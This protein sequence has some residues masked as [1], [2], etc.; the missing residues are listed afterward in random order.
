MS[1]NTAIERNDQRERQRA[2]NRLR[3]QCLAGWKQLGRLPERVT[4]S[5]PRRVEH[6]IRSCC[7]LWKRRGSQHL[8]VFLGPTALGSTGRQSRSSDK[9]AK[10]EVLDRWVDGDGQVIQG[11]G[12]LHLTQRGGGRLARDEG[13]GKNERGRFRGRAAAVM[14]G[15]E[16]TGWGLEEYHALQLGPPPAP[17]A[18]NGRLPGEDEQTFRD[19]MRR[20]Q[21]LASRG[22]QM[23]EGP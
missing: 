2:Y 12:L 14:P 10:P 22:L 18:P 19:R 7:E 15:P 17:A 4:S 20:D 6:L 3:T 23:A 5:H 1:P 11:M 16:I 9:R 21:Y 13:G 8:E